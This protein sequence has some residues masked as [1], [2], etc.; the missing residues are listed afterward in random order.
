MRTIFLVRHGQST[1]NL[2]RR[3]Q[4]QTPHPPLTDLGRAQAARAAEHLRSALGPQCRPALW[5]SDLV[6]ARQTADVIGAALGLTPQVS[7]AL[8]EQS[9]GD[10]EGRGYGELHPEDH[11][12]GSESL[13][14]SEI[15][16]GGGESVLDVHRRLMPFLTGLDDGT[17]ILVSHGDAI[18]VALA[19]LDGRTHREVDWDSPMPNGVVTRRD[20]PPA[21]EPDRATGA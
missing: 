19:I 1:W 21:T 18:R 2:A 5:T 6:R 16:W 3:L 14:I 17:H 20:W 13:D 9:I 15:R 7:A 4:G 8:R 10:L 12:E 11:P